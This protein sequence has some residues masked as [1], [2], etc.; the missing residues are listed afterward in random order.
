MTGFG[1]V[2]KPYMKC[3]VKDRIS[4]VRVHADAK[5]LML[6]PNLKSR[7]KLFYD[8]TSTTKQRDFINVTFTGVVTDV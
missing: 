7:I 4:F 5:M 2:L 3:P 6:I 8:L 1:R